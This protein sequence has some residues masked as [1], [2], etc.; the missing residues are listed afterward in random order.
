MSIEKL[1][2]WEWDIN[3]KTIQNIYICFKT[4]MRNKRFTHRKKK[5]EAAHWL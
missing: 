4:W 2:N 1:N 5:K 3:E